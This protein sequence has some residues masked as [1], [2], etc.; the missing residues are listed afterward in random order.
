MIFAVGILLSVPR[1]LAPGER[2]QSFSLGTGSSGKTFDLETTIRVAEFKFIDWKGGSEPIRQNSLFKD[3]Y[4]LAEHPTSKVKEL[5]VIGTEHP[6]TFLQGARA[7]S[8]VMS[9][10]KLRGEYQVKYQERF[11]TVSDYYS[12]RNDEVRLQDLLEVLP[13]LARSQ[14]TE[15]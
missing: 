12:F 5:F 2:I 3:F 1:I 4:L 15:A 7:L 6:L 11:T 10:N 9:N 8:S 13:G 14:I